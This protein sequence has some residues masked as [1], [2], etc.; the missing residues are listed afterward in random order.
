MKMFFYHP[1]ESFHQRWW[2]LLN[3][4]AVTPISGSTRY[5]SD[6]SR[7]TTRCLKELL[8]T[9]D[10]FFDTIC[11][12]ELRQRCCCKPQVGLSKKK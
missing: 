3:V 6:W 8:E 5:K 7:A 4:D 12:F 9:G 1:E 11:L 10:I 2:N